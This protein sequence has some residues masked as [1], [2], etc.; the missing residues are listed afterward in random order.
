MLT[1]ELSLVR[2][3]VNGRCVEQPSVTPLDFENMKE[4]LL[5]RCPMNL[6]KAI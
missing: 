4:P 6:R 3:L 1:L 5:S 2:Y